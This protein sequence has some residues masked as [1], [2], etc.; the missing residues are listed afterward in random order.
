MAIGAEPA[1]MTPMNATASDAITKPV[2]IHLWINEKLE[3]PYRPAQIAEMLIAGDLS[4]EDPASHAGKDDWKPLQELIGS[5][6]MRRIIELRDRGPQPHPPKASDVVGGSICVI[7]GIAFGFG[8]IMSAGSEIVNLH[9]LVTKAVCTIG[10][11][12]A[13]V[14][15]VGIITAGHLKRIATHLQEGSNKN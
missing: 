15:G 4:P 14:L 1:Y 6:R 13:C 11:L 5:E 8:V 9:A 2:E 7:G 10:G 12:L 3:G